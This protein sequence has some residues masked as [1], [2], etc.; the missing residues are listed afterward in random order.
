MIQVQVEAW[1]VFLENGQN[2]LRAG[3][4]LTTQGDAEIYAEVYLEHH[5]HEKFVR[6]IPIID[7]A[8]S[9]DN[10]VEIWS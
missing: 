8:F 4:T 1:G 2:V 6:L 10:F 5:P 9:W 7:G 3:Q